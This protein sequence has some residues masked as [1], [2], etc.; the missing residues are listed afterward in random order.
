MPVCVRCRNGGCRPAPQLKQ[1]KG[2]QQ[3]GLMFVGA[4]G[5][6]VL[7]DEQR[8]ARRERVGAPCRA[9][10]SPHFSPF[11]FCLRVT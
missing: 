11:C 2:A 8:G 6:S 3:W 1:S 9:P 10:Y 5:S 4:W 7:V